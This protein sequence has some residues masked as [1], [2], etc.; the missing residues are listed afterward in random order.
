MPMFITPE[1]HIQNAQLVTRSSSGDVDI[2]HEMTP[3]EAVKKFADEGASMLQ[4]FDIDAA[5]LLPDN[6]E[7]LIKQLKEK[8]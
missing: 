4:I 8:K 7:K 3:Q 5:K 6:N 2:F 1:I